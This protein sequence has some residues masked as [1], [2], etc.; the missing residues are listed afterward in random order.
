MPR[1]K[2]RRALLAL[3][4]IVLAGCAAGRWHG[5]PPRVHEYAVTVEHAEAPFDQRRWFSDEVYLAKCPAWETTY[6]W[7]D[8]DRNHRPTR[9]ERVRV[10]T[11]CASAPTPE[12]SNDPVR[13]DVD[14]EGRGSI[15]VGGS[16]SKR[17]DTLDEMSITETTVTEVTFIDAEGKRQTVLDPESVE[18]YDNAVVIRFGGKTGRIVRPENFIELRWVPKPEA[19]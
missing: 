1:P 4:P 10:E 15:G 9:G 8:R 17:D 7:V 14:V 12:R 13:V 2:R 5:K 16:G 19:P 18:F 6:S 11:Q 3:L